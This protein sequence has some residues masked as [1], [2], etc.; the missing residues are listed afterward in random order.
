MTEGEGFLTRWAR[1][2]RAAA[3]E[4]RQPRP[5]G[6]R[7]PAA[8]TPAAPQETVSSF[9][10]ASL[11]RLETIGAGSDIRPF[12]A[13]DVPADLKRRALRRAWTA[14]P[15][16]RDFIGLS[17][18]SWDFSVSGGVPGFGSVTPEEARRILAQIGQETGAPDPGLPTEP[19]RQASGIGASHLEA[20]GDRQT[21][22][23]NQPSSE[24]SNIALHN[25]GREEKFC[26][27]LPRRRHGGALPD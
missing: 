13:P 5:G 18:N 21:D 19:G 27:P 4:Q 15:A 25:N 8:P 24:K 12:L 23:G 7:E 3:A 20:G 16:I 14:D 1:R 26:L 6:I 10:P 22:D 17:E 11:P 9:D 2:K